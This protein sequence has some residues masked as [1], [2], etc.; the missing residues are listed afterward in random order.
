M[1]DESKY[2]KQNS[3]ILRISMSDRVDT[4]CDKY[5][6]RRRTR[7]LYSLADRMKLHEI[8]CLYTLHV[9]EIQK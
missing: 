6:C 5:V 4:K 2:E 9:V 1:V 3:S 8:R 7:I